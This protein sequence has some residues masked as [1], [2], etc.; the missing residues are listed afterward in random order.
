MENKVKWPH[1][2]GGA[3]SLGPGPSPCLLS[4]WTLLRSFSI[5]LLYKAGYRYCDISERGNR[6]DLQKSAPF[7]GLPYSGAQS[8]QPHFSDEALPAIVLPGRVVRPGSVC[9]DEWCEP[10][11]AL[12]FR[13]RDRVRVLSALTEGVLLK[14]GL[15]GIASVTSR[16]ALCP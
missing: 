15:E 13:V 8:L 12:A 9:G 11:H 6:I 10:P 16:T 5:A 2:A 1:P 7:P 3:G 4:K 14:V